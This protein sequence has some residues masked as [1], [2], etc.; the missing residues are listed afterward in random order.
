MT[1]VHKYDLPVVL[2]IQLQPRPNIVADKVSVSFWLLDSCFSNE[3]THS[4][5]QVMVV[6]VMTDT[7]RP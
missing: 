7:P 5:Y 4:I 3:N 2:R 6:T 1:V